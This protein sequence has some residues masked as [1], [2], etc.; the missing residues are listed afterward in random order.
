MYMVISYNW[1]NK[2]LIDSKSIGVFRTLLQAKQFCL[3][4]IPYSHNFNT[5]AVIKVRT[6][7]KS[8]YKPLA[9]FTKCPV[10]QTWASVAADDVRNDVEVTY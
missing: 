6:G 10:Y 2:K 1:I 3:Y 9:V 4:N 7:A 8:H 5:L